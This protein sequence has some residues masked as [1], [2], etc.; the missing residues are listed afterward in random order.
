MLVEMIVGSLPWRHGDR[1]ETYELKRTVTDA[2]LFRDKCPD[3]LR[4]AYKCDNTNTR[5]YA[6][7]C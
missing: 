5:F 2:Q 4:I 7:L 3:E 6:N 1:S